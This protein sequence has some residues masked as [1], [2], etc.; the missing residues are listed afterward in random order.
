MYLLLFWFIISILVALVFGAMAWYGS[1]DQDPEA[2]DRESTID[3]SRTV[4]Q[5]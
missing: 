5:K 1:R 3:S 2:E 4:L